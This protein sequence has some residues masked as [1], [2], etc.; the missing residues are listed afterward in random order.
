MP[1]AQMQAFAALRTKGNR[2]AAERR[3]LLIEHREAVVEALQQWQANLATIEDKILVYDAMVQSSDMTDVKANPQPSK[4]R[5]WPTKPPTTQ[6]RTQTTT[7]T[8]GD[9]TSSKKSTARRASA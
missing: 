1:I 5:P 6:T 4:D 7:A 2:T 8:H 3:A 9:R